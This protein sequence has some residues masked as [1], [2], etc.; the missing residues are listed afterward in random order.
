MNLRGWLQSLPDP[1][2][3]ETGIVNEVKYVGPELLAE[4]AIVLMEACCL[5]DSEYPEG[6]INSIYFDTPHRL[7]HGEKTDG[8]N[9]KLKVR[10]RWYG[11]PGRPADADIPVFIEAKHRL[12][13]ARRK[14]RIS[15]M[16]SERWICETPLGDP[17]FSA[18]L[19]RHAAALGEPIPQVLSPTVCIS[20]ARRRY[21]CPE[22]GSRIA[23]D[24]DIR[25]DR[26]NALQFPVVARIRLDRAVCEFKNFHK[27]P[28]TWTYPLFKAGFRLRSFSKYGECMNQLL[29]G[30][31]PL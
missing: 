22:T 4:Q 12:G 11:R 28:P 5:S 7:F 30:G 1:S 18:F 6:K 27:E 21:L 31:A 13:S 14:Q 26:I 3:Q 29:L 9:L 8:D 19:Y 10:I 15:V 24:R 25:A 17:S 23:I 16:A 2:A 20:Y